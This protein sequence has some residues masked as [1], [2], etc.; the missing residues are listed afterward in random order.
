MFTDDESLVGGAG[1]DSRFEDV[2]R[3]VSRLPM[4]PERCGRLAAKMV[5]E[6]S[7]HNTRR[8]NMAFDLDKVLPLACPGASG[9][10][11]R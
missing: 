11:S 4:R 6:Y 10:G 7:A 8:K 5:V 9:T 2:I 1:I 3:S